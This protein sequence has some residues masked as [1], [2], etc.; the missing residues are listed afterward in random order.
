M[1]IKC[2][3]KCA[4]KHP[5]NSPVSSGLFVINDRGKSRLKMKSNVRAR[6]LLRRHLISN[7]QTS[8]DEPV[9][10]S[11]PSH[12]NAPIPQSSLFT[13]LRNHIHMNILAPQN[14]QKNLAFM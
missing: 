9:I 5:L 10:V 1:L 13:V 3:L 14:T 8:F 12:R 7:A 2:A 4:L 11:P 6:A